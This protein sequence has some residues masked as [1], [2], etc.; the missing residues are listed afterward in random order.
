[1]R[2][3]DRVPP[4]GYG[5]G[6]VEELEALRETPGRPVLVFR[7]AGDELLALSASVLHEVAEWRP[8]HTI[9]H[10]RDGLV[11]GVVNLGGDLQVCVSLEALLDLPRPDPGVRPRRGR[12]LAI[13]VRGI[14][15]AVLVQDTLALVEVSDDDLSAPPSTIS[16]SASPYVRGLF[17]WH[18]EQV[19]LLDEELVLATLGRR[20]A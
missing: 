7:V 15:W 13:G 10:Q 16:A 6:W 17:T 3:L 8:V 9:P 14:E 11:L 12:L 4:D 19:G 18:D 2:L 1:M 20:I 5:E